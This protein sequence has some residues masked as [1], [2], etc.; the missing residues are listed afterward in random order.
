[1][2]QYR[3]SCNTP[4][5]CDFV[6]VLSVR[7]LIERLKSETV[8]LDS[9]ITS[10]INK[11]Y[12]NLPSQTGDNEEYENLTPLTGETK[13]LGELIREFVITLF[14]R[15]KAFVPFYFV[16]GER[17][18]FTDLPLDDTR[19]YNIRG[20]ID[21]IDEMTDGRVRIAMTSA[22]ISTLAAGPRMRL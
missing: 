13:I 1:M 6:A 10:S 22:V 20:S 11:L 16:E 15:E 2:L 19:S 4:L 18:V 12:N 14:D 7:S 17:E 3:N 5:L 9:I 8:K 21:R